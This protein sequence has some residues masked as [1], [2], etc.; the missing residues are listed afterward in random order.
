MLILF[1]T[2]LLIT[3]F[4][5][6][7]MRILTLGPSPSAARLFVMSVRET[8]AVYW[9]ADLFY[10]KEDIA[11]FYAV[12]AV[13]EEPE[14]DASLISLP[15][16]N[17]G[18]TNAE[19]AEAAI[20]DSKNTKPDESSVSK[21][22]PPG[23]Q[24]EPRKT[25]NGIEVIDITGSTY[26][27]KLMIVADPTRVLVGVPDNFGEGYK[28][29][30]VMQMIEKYGC[31]A[32]MNA[33]GF[34]DPNGKGTGAVPDGIVISDGKLLWGESD[35]NYNL[36]GIDGEGLLHVGTMSASHALDIGI[37]YAASF[38]PALVINGVPCNQRSLFGGG[39]NPRTVIG[40]RADG[41]MLLLVINGR[42]IN[43]LGATLDDLVE[44]ML[45]YDAVNAT[46]L[47]GG[48]SSLMIYNGECITDSAYVFGVRAIPTAI[49]VKQ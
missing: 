29:L 23:T 27:G 34:N 11:A 45:K 44:I 2:L 37:K 5:Y 8:S 6:G 36:A 28:G 3:A 22:E 30:T 20:P 12:D 41:A 18:D 15:S 31:V 16:D 17:A 13:N 24:T 14:M 7:V 47:D 32:G 4:L 48:S 43:S 19:T 33:G 25:D 49:L 9:L 35:S 1:T 38:G 40:Q 46:N 21:T 10:S 39:L 26:Y 42:Q